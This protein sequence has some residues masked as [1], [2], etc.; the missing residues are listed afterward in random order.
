M[1]FYQSLGFLVFGSRL[2]RLS[3]VFINDVNN[4]YN[5]HRIPFDASWFPVFYILSTKKQITI[6]EI[7]EELN[8]SHSAASQLISGLQQKGLLTSVQS[9]T[10]GRKK[11]VSLTVK[12][13]KLL[14]KIK[15]IWYALEQA[16][17]QL[18]T[19]GKE[20]KKILKSLE[21]IEKNLNQKTILN[22]VE[23][24]MK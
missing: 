24:L 11:A 6:R 15:P 22:R 18:A 14:L 17:E 7:S 21:E 5:K 23:L 13:E 8:I 1:N 3:D 16:M 19:E 10:D 20:S 2:K 12:G 9:K 4:I